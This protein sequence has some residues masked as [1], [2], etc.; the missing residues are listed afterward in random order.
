MGGKGPLQFIYTQWLHISVTL[1]DPGWQS[2]AYNHIWY[3]CSITL[4]IIWC[5]ILYHWATLV[6]SAWTVSGFYSSIYLWLP[7]TRV[8]VL[9]PLAHSAQFLFVLILVTVYFNS[10]PLFHDVELH[11]LIYSFLWY[12]L[13]T[14]GQMNPKNLPRLRGFIVCGC[15]HPGLISSNSGDNL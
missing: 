6:L 8:R 10:A 4:S 3:G 14:I 11:S 2:P 9:S 13:Y 12:L 5:D 15:I 7:E 1:R